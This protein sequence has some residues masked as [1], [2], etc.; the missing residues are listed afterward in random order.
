MSG[1]LSLIARFANQDPIVLAG[2]AAL[3]SAKTDG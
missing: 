3:E 1:R 2:L